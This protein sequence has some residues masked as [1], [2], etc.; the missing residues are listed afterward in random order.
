VFVG[1]VRCPGGAAAALRPALPAPSWKSV[2][3]VGWAG[4]RGIVSLAAAIG[5]ADELPAPRPHP[6]H[7]VRA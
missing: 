6:V 4:M 1:D 2:A 3:I 7:H 5:A